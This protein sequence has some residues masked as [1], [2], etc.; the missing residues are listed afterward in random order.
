MRRVVVLCLLFLFVSGALSRAQQKPLEKPSITPMAPTTGPRMEFLDE[1]SY[2][3]QRYER[4]ADAIPAQKFNWRPAE[5]V[6]TVGEVYM[7]IVTA[8]YTFAKMLGTPPPAGYDPKALLAES[9]DKAAVMQSLKDSFAHFREAIL[10]L[11]DADLT[12][13]VK[14]PRGQTTIR[15][16]F[17]IITGHFGEHLGQ[18]IAY[19]RTIGIVPPWT[20]E[21]MRQESDKSKP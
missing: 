4:L 1:V 10:D 2:Y 6:R 17:F 8:N 18:S 9:T 21:R 5:G 12:K 15:G 3:E 14:T 19:A 7:H 13:E 11:K 20:E 16:A